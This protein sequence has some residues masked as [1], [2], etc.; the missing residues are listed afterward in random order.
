MN[1]LVFALC[2]DQSTT[3]STCTM[4]V[5][6]RFIENTNHAKKAHAFAD[7]LRDPM[8]PSVILV[9][10]SREDYLGM[11]AR[12]LLNFGIARLR[13]VDCQGDHLR[14]SWLASGAADVLHN[15]ELHPTL[16]AACHDV[17]HVF[18]VVP[19]GT[20]GNGALNTAILSAGQAALETVRLA[21]RNETEPM[22]SGEVDQQV[23]AG[24]Q[25]WSGVAFLFGAS[26]EELA[27]LPSLALS[28]R[29]VSVCTHAG[30]P[31]ELP[32]V[33]NILGYESWKSRWQ[34]SF[35]GFMTSSCLF[36]CLC[37]SRQIPSL[38]FFSLHSSMRTE[39][40]I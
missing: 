24:A 29:R 7:A 37:V 11:V 17:R 31:L 13:L 40:V 2:V 36:F 28:Y 3:W 25:A 21:Q 23:F 33:V 5:G 32:Q 20:D 35:A 14:Q 16:E 38:A 12:N 9:R 15:A 1:L 22:A 30:L 26:E 6:R 8:A 18:A 10:E 39:I 19:P 27:L 4:Q 34:P